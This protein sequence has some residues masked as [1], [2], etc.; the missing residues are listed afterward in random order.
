MSLRGCV[1]NNDRK[2]VSY[3]APIGYRIEGQVQ[4][5]TSGATARGS[6]GS[7]SQYQNSANITISCSG[8]LCD[9]NNEEWISGYLVGKIRKIVTDQEIKEIQKQCLSQLSHN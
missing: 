2:I 6:K 3:Q 5:H 9:K 7:V 4:F 1:V 8:N